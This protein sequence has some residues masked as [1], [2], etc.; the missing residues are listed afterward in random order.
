[1]FNKINK[2]AIKLTNNCNFNCYY[3]VQK[4]SNDYFNDFSNLK[5]FLL[6][7]SPSFTPKV[8]FRILGG[9]PL[10]DK[11]KFFSL[12]YFVKNIE[13]HIKSNFYFTTSSNGSNPETLIEAMDYGFITENGATISWDGIHSCKSRKSDTID[14]EFLKNSLKKIGESGHQVNIVFA[15][16][17]E[18]VDYLYES[19][20]FSLDCGIKNFKTYYIDNMHYSDELAV[21]YEKQLKLVA[22]EFIERYKFKEKR[23]KFS[24]YNILLFHMKRHNY[25]P[26]LCRNF[27]RTFHIGVNG[28][29]YACLFAE[30]R[31]NMRFGNIENGL[32][33]KKLIEFSKAFGISPYSSWNCDYTK[34]KNSHCFECPASTYKDNKIPHRKNTCKLN[35]IFRLIFENDVLRKISIN[36]NDLKNF[37]NIKENY[38]DIEEKKFGIIHPCLL[39]WRDYK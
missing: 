33:V 37:W 14:D 38:D 25:T 10:Y 1:M 5:K 7:I 39:D 2:L 8:N 30:D 4:H 9:E 22:K 21:K 36:E 19:L 15:I 20:L 32:N 11:D 18:T 17:P 6:K 26:I 28:D 16:T 27:G 34:C 23:F 13:R 29:V 35:T 3:C 12:I 24:D 31:N